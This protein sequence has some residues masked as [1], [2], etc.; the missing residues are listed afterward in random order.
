MTQQIKVQPIKAATKGEV[1]RL[2]NE[3]YVPISLQHRG[4]G[5]QH[6]QTQAR[7]LDE[8]IRAHGAAT[9]IELSAEDGTTQEALIHDVQRD[10]VSQRLL[11]VALQL[12]VR[13]EA[14]KVQVPLSFHGIPE[15]VHLGSAVLSHS[16]EH[17]EVRSL[18]RNLP[19]HI[20]ADVSHLTFGQTLRVADLPPTDRYEILTPADT[21]LAFLSSVSKQ[22]VEA[23]ATPSSTS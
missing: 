21:V 5:T 18:P 10:A 2:R 19:D 17:L 13:G 23:A 11:H 1:K 9:R 12:I 3:G 7:P 6:F 8:F 4:E 22:A 16:I 20:D 14:M 15:A